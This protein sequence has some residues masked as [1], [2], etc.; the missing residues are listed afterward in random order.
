MC[1]PPLL[2]PLHG[3]SKVRSHA[4][5]CHRSIIA[6]LFALTLVACS[7]DTTQ[8]VAPGFLGGTPSNHEVGLVVNSLGKTLA[9]FQLGSP[10]TQTQIPLGSSSTVTPT[11]FAVRGRRAV[12]P[13]GNAASVALINLETA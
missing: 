11:G 9:L 3:G 4:F 2:N 10:T 7:D 12:V 13:L 8:P 1:I 6:P 5:L